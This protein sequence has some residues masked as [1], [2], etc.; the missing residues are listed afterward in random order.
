[1][2]L[3][4]WYPKQKIHSKNSTAMSLSRNHDLVTQDNPQT[5][6]WAVSWTTIFFLLNYTHQP[7]HCTE[8]SV[9]LL[10]AHLAPL[11]SLML[12]LIQGGRHSFLHLALSQAAYHWKKVVPTWNC[13]QQGLWIILSN[14]VMI[15]HCCWV[16]QM[17]FLGAFSTKSHVPSSSVIF[18]RRQT[19]LWP[20]SPTLCNSH[21]R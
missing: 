4:L 3:G 20:I 6:L 11:S 15:S 18:E 19:S 1:M 10:L 5:L 21:Y 14:K 12:Q 8:G 7:N 17:Y 2:A 16:F 9:H 13:S